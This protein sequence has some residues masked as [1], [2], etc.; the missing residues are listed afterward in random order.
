MLLLLPLL[1]LLDAVVVAVATAGR[2]AR[3]CACWD[4]LTQAWEAL[5]GAAFSVA[6][7]R[8]GIRLDFGFGVQMSKVFR[9]N[10]V[11]KHW[12]IETL[13]GPHLGGHC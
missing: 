9:L 7:V 8:F 5:F 3:R 13:S 4:T 1:L 2:T 6:F 12:A 11:S 10:S